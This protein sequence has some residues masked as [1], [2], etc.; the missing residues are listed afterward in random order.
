MVRGRRVRSRRCSSIG[1]VGD[2]VA[3]TDRKRAALEV[4]YFSG[5]GALIV[6]LGG[7]ALARMA[8][9]LARDV[10][11]THPA[12][13]AAPMAAADTPPT[14]EPAV[15]PARAGQFAAAEREEPRRGLFHRAPAVGC[16]A[17]ATTSAFRVRLAAARRYCSWR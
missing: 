4:A 9:R 16:S 3:A 17:D 15:T 11:A 1:A 12:P 6:F 5:L 8:V 10:V 7:A 13:V 14:A 2:P